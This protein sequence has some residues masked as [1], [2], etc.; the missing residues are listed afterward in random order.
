MFKLEFDT[1]DEAFSDPLEIARILERVAL[2]VKWGDFSSPIFDINGNRIGSWS[3]ASET[4]S[5]P[6]LGSELYSSLSRPARS[7]KP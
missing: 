4:T 2:Q 6:S 5:E 3:L 1:R 7:P